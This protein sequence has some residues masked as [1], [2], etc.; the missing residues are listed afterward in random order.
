MCRVTLPDRRSLVGKF[1]MHPMNPYIGGPEVVRWIKSWVPRKKPVD[2]RVEPGGTGNSLRLS[3][4]G[5]GVGV[6]LHLAPGLKRFHRRLK[7]ARSRKAI[8]KVL[9]TW[10]RDPALRKTALALWGASCQVK[11]CHALD[12]VPTALHAAMLDVHHLEH[13][14]AGGDDSLL[15]ICVLCAGHHAA[16]HRLRPSSLVACDF[17]G[18]TVRVGGVDVQIVR[19]LPDLWAAAG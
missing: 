13:V 18:A 19:H 9:E 7:K 17:R 12:G 16:V 1:H 2:A 10:E 8:Q 3:F 14:S 15:N 4:P 6:A 11:G 5:A